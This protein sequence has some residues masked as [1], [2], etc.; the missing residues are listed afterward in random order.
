MDPEATWKILRDPDE[1]AD[2]RRA[3]AVYLLSWLANGGHG[4]A[5]YKLHF[6][7]EQCELRLW[8]ALDK[9]QELEG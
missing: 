1:D 8:A 4:I 6:V 3:A 2:A 7:I 9:L 5:E